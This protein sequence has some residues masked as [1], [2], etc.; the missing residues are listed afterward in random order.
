MSFPRANILRL[1]PA[2]KERAA[3]AFHLTGFATLHLICP[4]CQRAARARH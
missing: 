3:I 4:W 2:M 1:P